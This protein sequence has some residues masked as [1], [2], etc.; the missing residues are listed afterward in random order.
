MNK[1]ST[2]LRCAHRECFIAQLRINFLK[3]QNKW[4]KSAHRLVTKAN[5][6]AQIN[7]IKAFFWLVV[8][9]NFIFKHRIQTT[10]KIRMPRGRYEKKKIS[11]KN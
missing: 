8:S 3:K 2:F 5:R 9:F 11:E 4:E 7:Q 6:T 1:K 10:P